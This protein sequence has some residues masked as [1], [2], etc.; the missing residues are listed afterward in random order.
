M[1]GHRVHEPALT[2]ILQPA[3][4]QGREIRWAF[5]RTREDSARIL[6]ASLPF[7]CLV[8]I[9]IVVVIAGSGRRLGGEASKDGAGHG[10]VL[11]RVEFVDGGEAIVTG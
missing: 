2:G 10:L 3:A 5:C 7:R 9:V 11:V 6:P 8:L 4:A 1:G